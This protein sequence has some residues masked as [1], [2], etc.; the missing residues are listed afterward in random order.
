MVE[1]V[2]ES[3]F[4]QEVKLTIINA[5]SIYIALKNHQNMQKHSS[6]GSLTILSSR[7][8]V[9]RLQSMLTVKINKCSNTA[10]INFKN[11]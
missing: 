1:H 4:W 11:F 10:N 6:D 2:G 3:S 9:K 5:I 7:A 8:W